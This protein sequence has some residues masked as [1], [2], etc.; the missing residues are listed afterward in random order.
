[1]SISQYTNELEPLPPVYPILDTAALERIG[2]DIVL[3]AEAFLEGGARILQY[4]HKGF[5]SRDVFAQAGRV[6]ELCR[7]AKAVF[8][9]NDRA[10]YAALL[11]AG[12]HVGQD[13]LSPSDARRMIGGGKVLGFSTHSAAQ[14][15]AAADEPVDYVAFGPVF[16]TQSKA[17][18]DTTVGLDSLRLARGLTDRPLVAIGGITRENA[19]ACFD[20]GADSVAVISDLLPVTGGKQALRDR[21]EEWQ[22]LLRFEVR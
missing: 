6:T 19:R 13:D 7:D 18:A 2:L 20:A 16:A 11:G 9:L 5:W 21:M 22:G 4:R 17:Q 10:D 1:M 3:A 15:R 14:M 8:I 12:L